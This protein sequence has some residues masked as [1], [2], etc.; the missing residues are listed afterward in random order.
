[1]N[2]ELTSINWLLWL[3]L[4][5]V[6]GLYE[7]VG[8]KNTLATANLQAVSASNSSILMYLI[9]VLGTYVCI[10]DGLINLI[11]IIIGAWLGTYFSIKWEIKLKKRNGAKRRIKIG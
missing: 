5:P 3:A 7:Y 10:V 8:T 2:V 4:L 6:Y 1:M 11:P 9:G